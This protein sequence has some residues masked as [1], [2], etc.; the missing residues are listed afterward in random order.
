MSGVDSV[1]DI[2]LNARDIPDGRARHAYLMDACGGDSR[3]L[4]SVLTMLRDATGADA[5]FKVAEK[6]V[7][8][9]ASPS[10]A[11]LPGTMIG[12]YKVLQQI[13][14]GGCGVVYMAEQEEPVR[15]RVALKI[16]R[17][18]MDTKSVIARFEAERQ[19]L[20]LMDHPN[21]AKVLDAGSTDNGRP[22]FVMEL[23]RGV[24][25]TEYC[26]EKAL[27]T[28]Q[29]LELFGQVCHA[30]QHAH[31]KG[32][33]HRDIKPSNVLVTV[34]DGIA[35]PK[36][37]D[38]GI[39]KAT[40]DQRLTD[41]TVF[42]AFE[43]FIG[44]PAYM[45][46]EQ[47]EITSVDVDTRS[48][49]YSLGVLLYELLTGKTPFDGKELLKIGLDEMRR[50]IREKEPERPSTKVSTLAGDELT[51]T[52]K[53][54]GVEAPKLA[55]VLRGDLDW[56]VMKCLEKDRARRY[57]TANGLAMDVGRHLKNEA[58][59][60]CPPS[61]LYRFGKLLRRHKS[62][63]AAAAAMLALLLGGIGLSTTEAV[64]ARRAEREAV[65]M[66]QQALKNETKAELEKARSDQVAQFLG[67][68]FEGA[69]PSVALGRDTTLLREI[70]DNAAARIRPE[71]TNQPEVEREMRVVMGRT[72]SDIGQSAAAEAMYREAFEIGKKHYGTNDSDA[73]IILLL[74]SD[75]LNTQGKKEETQIR[76]REALTIFRE[77]SNG[78]EKDVCVGL[79]LR[80][81]GQ[82]LR[83]QGRLK[84]SEEAFRE[85]LERN[86]RAGGSN[87]LRV[88]TALMCLANDVRDL[89]RPSEAEGML[90]RSLAIRIAN[91]VPENDPELGVNLH[92]LAVTLYTEGKF[93]DAEAAARKSFGIC[94]NLVGDHPEVA[95]PTFGR[96]M[97]E[98]KQLG[99]ILQKEGNFEEAERSDREALNGLQKVAEALSVMNVSQN[100][101][102]L[103]ARGDALARLGRWT[104]AAVDFARVCEL[105]PDDYGAAHMLAALL[106][107]NGD[108]GRYRVHCRRTLEKLENTRDAGTA[109]RIAKDCLI[110]PN[111]GADLG[112]LARLA[113]I[114]IK[115]Q[116]PKNLK[117]SEF[118]KGLVEYRLGH[119][120]DAVSWMQKVLYGSDIPL[121]VGDIVPDGRER[122]A[123]A[124][125]V[126][127]MA[128]H[129]S[130]Q[131]SEARASLA[132][133]LSYSETKLPKVGVADLGTQWVDWLLAHELVREAQE[134][135]ELPAAK[136][137]N[138]SSSTQGQSQL[139]SR[140]QRQ[141]PISAPASQKS[142]ESEL[143]Q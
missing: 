2:Y 41:K 78:K 7:T 74:L 45:S 127:A 111:S 59:V 48:D 131:S 114:S 15:R 44:T 33:I 51:T 16:I 134:L 54:R 130:Q 135:I 42:T 47:A 61:N 121:P 85:C 28:E 3:L 96:L 126:L 55:N 25:I 27:L 128:Q 141:T 29:R 125:A 9:R 36:V 10:T 139:Q 82:W 56:I 39:A 72:Y 98:Y 53:R 70:L 13:G 17:L 30:I 89:G 94:K 122:D 34:N 40:T 101:V 18:G 8:H 5:Y 24:K 50:T 117:G 68:T 37:I 90:Q 21:I 75:V 92:N 142:N 124:L 52:A 22:Y 57:E 109:D 123:A 14:E 110:V 115:D 58:V 12:R 102:L 79:G 67:K 88:A 86:I 26:D 116:Q 81:L 83:W 62:A 20:A 6:A 100:A 66:R 31:Q 69:R 129:Q 76:I 119:F 105:R 38:F 46:P 60:A 143:H 138:E 35:V 32:I 106:A 11:E 108:F 80:Y 120:A 103:S 49:I 65:K 63:F 4:E 132:T 77:L 133:A 93:K 137:M 1:D 113:D 91:H 97:Q 87:D 112:T 95:L 23:V 73:G 19:A 71:L 43:Q 107:H 64:R 140:A 118:C 99:A 84:E 104:E 136:A